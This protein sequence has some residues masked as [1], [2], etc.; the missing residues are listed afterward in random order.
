MTVC[1]E[2]P[3]VWA[4]PYLLRHMLG[5]FGELLMQAEADVVSAAVG[6]GR[7]PGA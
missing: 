4:R 2:Q 3:L 5:T 6:R 7:R 1:L